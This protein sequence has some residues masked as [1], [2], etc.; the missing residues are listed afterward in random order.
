MV[1]IGFASQIHSMYAWCRN[2]IGMQEI[3]IA[4]PPPKVII[5]W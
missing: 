3:R 4:V 1:F 2:M 5:F